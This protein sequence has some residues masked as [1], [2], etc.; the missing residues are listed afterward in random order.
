MSFEILKLKFKLPPDVIIEYTYKNS[1]VSPDLVVVKSD[2][3]SDSDDSNTI[4]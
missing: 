2:S 3:D 4:K 1:P